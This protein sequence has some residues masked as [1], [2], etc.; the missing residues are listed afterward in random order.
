MRTAQLRA[1]DSLLFIIIWVHRSATFWRLPCQKQLLVT[2]AGPLT[3][4]GTVSGHAHSI[5]GGSGFN[6]IMDFDTAR[7]SACTSCQVKQD[8]SNYWYPHLYFH[9]KN[10][11][12][13]AVDGGTL[14]VYYLPRNN[15]ADK[16]KVQAFPDGFRMLAGNPYVRS[17]DPNSEEPKAIGWNCIGGGGRNPWFPTENCPVRHVF[18][19][20]LV[21]HTD[22]SNS[23][24][25]MRGEVMFPSCWNGK[26]LDSSSHQSHVAYPE[27][28]ESGACPEGYPVRIETLFFEMWW[29]V[30]GFK[31]NWG[32]AMN[33]T[34]PWVLSTGDPTGYSLHGDFLN[35]WDRTILQKAIDTCTS[36]SGVI[37]ECKV[38]DFLNRY[39]YKSSTSDICHLTPH[40]REQVVGTLAALP[41]CNKVDPGPGLVSP[42]EEENPPKLNSNIVVYGGFGS[43]AT[44]P[45]AS[46]KLPQTSSSTLVSASKVSSTKTRL[47][48]SFASPAST[49]G[50][51]TT[52]NSFATKDDDVSSLPD[53]LIS[54]KVLAI[55]GISILVCLVGTVIYCVVQKRADKAANIEAVHDLGERKR[56]RSRQCSDDDESEL[57]V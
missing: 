51:I 57:S 45:V 26:D 21:F 29:S 27:G 53:S 31:T 10:G 5:A 22:F 13:T 46:S 3:N 35:G 42:C 33:T 39:D 14:L 19:L 1:R 7:S 49:T 4:P 54:M 12:F 32:E 47:S 48:N 2:R 36:D 44:L 52:P 18:L 38:F 23:K 8:L 24:D 17:Y 37:D 20:F 6:L 55:G 41:G 16:D 34:M 30:D 40:I 15:S 25:G 43:N 28:G 11:S 56:L 50:E 9:W